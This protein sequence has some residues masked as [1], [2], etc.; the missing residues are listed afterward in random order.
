ML[1]ESLEA[2]YD[3]TLAA[4]VIEPDARSAP[5]KSVLLVLGHTCGRD[6][7]ERLLGAGVSGILVP[8]TRL[9]GGANLVLW[10]W[11]DVPDRKVV[12]LDPQRDLP[13]DQSS[14]PVAPPA[15]LR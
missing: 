12:A 6:I 5:W 13:R 1:A 15:P 2:V 3:H 7:A 9:T 10:R 14:W 11:N 8:S 4:A